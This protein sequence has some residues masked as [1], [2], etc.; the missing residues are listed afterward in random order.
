MVANI[1]CHPP[2]QGIALLCAMLRYSIVMHV[3]AHVTYKAT[4]D[5]LKTSAIMWLNSTSYAQRVVG[6]G[7]KAQS[8]N[9]EVRVRG[10]DPVINQIVDKLKHVIQSIATS[11]SLVNE[12]QMSLLDEMSLLVN[13]IISNL[14]VPFQNPNSGVY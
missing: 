10:T 7:M 5:C 6:N 2:W 8:G 1:S 3:A 12:Q 11:V 4:I 9:P 14:K 13:P